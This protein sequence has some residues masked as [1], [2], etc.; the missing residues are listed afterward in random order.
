M[1]AAAPTLLLMAQGY[2]WSQL[3]IGGGGRVTSIKAHPKV[4]NLF[5]ITTDV[6]TCYRWNHGAQRWEALLVGTKVPVNYWTWEV[7]Q[8]CGDLVFDPQDVTGNI[9]YATV[10]NGA[11]SGPGL[12]SDTRGTVLKS[13]DRGETWTDCGLQVEVKPNKDQDITDRLAVDPLN[14][15]VIWLT[16]RAHGTWRSTA[17]GAP[18]SWSQVAGINQ[19]LGGR[20]IK[21]DISAGTVSGVTKN[22]FIGTTGGMYQST[23]G[24]ATFTQMVGGP[25][26]LLRASIAKDGVMFVTT[27]SAT[28]NGV[29]KWSGGSWSTVSPDP[30]RI[31]KS[32]MVNPDNSNEVI[33]ASSGSWSAELMW[34]STTGGNLGSWSLMSH[35][36]DKTEAPH[37]EM[38]TGAGNIG[39]SIDMIAFDPFNAGH[40]WFSDMINVSQTTN[41]W[42]PTVAWKLRVTGLEEIFVTGQMVAPR[43]GRALLNT[44]T[45]D[46]GGFDHTSLTEP[47]ARGMSSYI[48]TSSSIN[49]TAV[50]IQASDPNFIVRFG[51]DGWNGPPI[52][53]YSTNGGVSYTRITTYPT[54]NARGRVAVSATSRN[55]VWAPQGGPS[56]WSNTLGA[57]WTVCNGLPGGIVPAGDIYSIYAG[58]VPIAA[59]RVSGNI[60]YA[61]SRGTI[62]VSQDTGRNFSARASNLPDDAGVA[63]YA[64]L[65]ATPG[66]SGDIWFS[67]SGGLFHSV[68]TGRTFVR[69]AAAQIPNPK[70]LT[71]GRSDTT[72]GSHPVLFVHNS[73]SVVNGNTFAIHRSDDNGVSWTE[74]LQRVPGVVLNMCADQQG[75]VFFGTYGNGLFVGVP[76]AGPVTGV[77]INPPADTLVE[78]DSVR[79]AVTLSPLYPDNRNYSFSSTNPSVASVDANGWVKALSAGTAGIVVTTQDGGLKDTTLI[80][81]TPFVHITSVTLDTAV[82]MGLGNT[83]NLVAK[84]LPVDATNKKINWSSSDSS[85]VKVSAGGIITALKLGQATI[86]ATSADGGLSAAITI[87]VNTISAAINMGDTAVVANFRRDP[88]PFSWNWNGRTTNAINRT[89]LTN[90]AP[91]AVYKSALFGMDNGSVYNLSGLVPGGT[92]TVRLHFAEIDAN[93]GNGGRRFNVYVNNAKKIDLFDV[94]AAAGNARYKAV[95]REYQVNAGNTGV[96]SVKLEPYTGSSMINGIEIVMNTVDSVTLAGTTASVGVNDTVRL[97]PTVWPA[98]ASNKGVTWTTSNAAVATVSPTGLVTGTG[99]GNTYIYVITNESQRR[100]SVLVTADS[101]LVDSVRLSAS[102]DTVGIRNTRQLTATVFPANAS[103]KTVIWASADTNIVKVSTSGLLTGVSAGTVNVTATTRQGSKVAT[104]S[105]LS[106]LVPVTQVNLSKSALSIGMGDSTVITATVAPSNASNTLVTWTSSN[107]GIVTVSATGKIFPVAPGT[108]NITV[109]AQDGQGA[110]K[111]LPVTV[112]PLYT[113]GAITNGGF[114]S[115]LLNWART[116]N[117]YITETAADV[118]GGTRALVINGDGAAHNYNAPLLVP[119]N[120]KITVSFWAKTGGTNPYWAGAGFDILDSLGNKIGNAAV[121]IPVATST[122]TRFTITANTPANAKSL[123]LWVSKAGPQT[124]L[125]FLDD[126]CATVDATS[127]TLNA[128]SVKLAIGGTRK[129]SAVALPANATYPG[130]IWNSSNT[131]VATVDTA[132]LI[133][134]V[135]QGTAFIIAT[136]ADGLVKDTAFTEVLHRFIGVNCGDTTVGPFL[137]DHSYT[138]GSVNAPY[139]VTSFNTNYPYAGPA[140]LYPKRRYG[141][142]SYNFTGLT[143]GASYT[144]RLHFTEPYWTQAGKR[145]FSV[146]ANGTFVITNLDI[147]A[148]VGQYNVLVRDVPATADTAGKLKLEFITVIDNAAVAAIEILGYNESL[149]MSNGL[150]MAPKREEPLL[151]GVLVVTPNPVSGNIRFLLKG[152]EADNEQLQVTVIDLQGREAYRSRITSSKAP[153]QHEL[154]TGGR[155]KKGVYILQV[156]GKNFRKTTRVVI[157]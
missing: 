70:W 37:S 83:T 74:I 43:V 33:A 59:D 94:F 101:I 39:F 26:S 100:D 150:S 41:V 21:F 121:T 34:R 149:L 142:C 120:R 133:T 105:V 67:H 17:A 62:Y 20:F 31:Y 50:D 114:E 136:S 90:P 118:H 119:A 131:G 86:T 10:Q 9:L 6:G 129:L 45:G 52:G 156:Q 36:R 63:S 93:V 61:Y 64:H 147:Y 151:S 56:Y 80:T 8:I 92:Y 3:R 110:S 79:L 22:M 32:V 122:Y 155:L 154:L 116:G 57:T 11:G 24:G 84:I 76:T 137:A 104:T 102:K 65:E 14:S 117:S 73:N 112:M 144:V 88:R 115:G 1:L 15:N 48:A 30:A 55:F 123:G 29:W 103:D 12:G 27:Y 139:P 148:A 99:V 46:V 95:I 81:V 87:Y 98:I 134:G 4:P 113:C 109:T 19:T 75:R 141:N 97:V 28:A 44:A 38:S 89:G 128:D 2:N 138:G 47:P 54:A 108:A 16:T 126:F 60:F 53:A 69:V 124:G 25:T 58:Q 35:T 132:G 40:V 85:R 145:T 82:Y 127:V 72:A 66:I 77:S 135:G 106:V 96:I 125:L 68:D 153:A 5:F 146:K 107:T 13:T 111:V 78:T 130:V 51:S 18:G 157:L 91:E 23:D 140:A 42:A 49:I 143:A 152:L 71:V 7:S